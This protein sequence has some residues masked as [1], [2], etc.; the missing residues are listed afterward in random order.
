[1]IVFRARSNNRCPARKIFPWEDKDV[2]MRR[3][4]ILSFWTLILVGLAAWAALSAY[5][6]KPLS[7]PVGALICIIAYLATSPTANS[8]NNG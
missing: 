1:V 4:V 8:G 7:G 5:Y 6:G 3:L 2:A